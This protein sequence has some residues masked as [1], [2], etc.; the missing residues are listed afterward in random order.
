MRS[1]SLTYASAVSM[2][3]IFILNLYVGLVDRNLFLPPNT[4]ITPHYYLNWLITVIDL[5]ASAVLFIRPKKL[6]LLV[7][8][9]IV[10]PLVYLGGLGLDVASRLCLGAP[11]STCFPSA[12]ASA[13][14]LFFGS[15]TYLQA[16]FWPYTFTMITVLL[17][18]TLILTAGGL[19]RKSIP[20]TPVPKQPENQRE[21]GRL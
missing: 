17:V 10:W 3:L 6:E 21:T 18:L 14:Y 19:T 7:L 1:L 20:A 15:S 12:D 5:V 16:Y 13:G 8:S 4:I 11:A 9:G 2:F